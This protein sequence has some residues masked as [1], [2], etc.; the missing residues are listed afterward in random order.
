MSLRLVPEVPDLSRYEA[1]FASTQWNDTYRA[2]RK[3]LGETLDRSWY[4]VSAIDGDELVGSGR[5][6]S[7]GVL[8]AVVFDVIVAPARR[9]EGIGS[10]LVEDMVR[11]CR[12]AGVRDVLLFS[13]DGQSAFYERLGF[14]ARPESAPGMFIRFVP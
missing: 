6:V 8:Y 10:A 11:H 1:L 4:I 5:V 12:C 9:G 3:E 13:A 2:S 7:D 14:T